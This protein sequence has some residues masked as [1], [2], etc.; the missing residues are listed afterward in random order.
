MTI[1]QHGRWAMSVWQWS[2]LVDVIQS[3]FKRHDRP[4]NSAH[5]PPQC[6]PTARFTGLTMGDRRWSSA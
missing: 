1:E 3:S 4:R 5:C 2:M 6:A